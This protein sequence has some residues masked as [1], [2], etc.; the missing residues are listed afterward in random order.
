MLCA[1]TWFFVFP[2]FTFLW[3]SVCSR[4]AVWFCKNLY[5]ITYCIAVLLPCVF[6][7]FW[8]FSVWF[9]KILEYCCSIIECQHS[10]CVLWCCSY[11]VIFLFHKVVPQLHLF[12]LVCWLICSHSNLFSKHCTVLTPSQRRRVGIILAGWYHTASFPKCNMNLTFS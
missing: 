4:S 1:L 12:H 3:G 2:L 7:V 9:A 8:I 5:I 11:K 6:V 10:P